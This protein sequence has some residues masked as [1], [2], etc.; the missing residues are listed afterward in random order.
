MGREQQQQVKESNREAE[1]ERKKLM[2]PSSGTCEEEEEEG[3][4]TEGELE[5]ECSGAEAGKQLI[6]KYSKTAVQSSGAVIC[7]MHSSSSP[8]KA[9]HRTHGYSPKDN[10]RKEL[11]DPCV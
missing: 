1:Q 10:R 3:E 2:G 6:Y 5:E 7:T 11:R 4:E 8:L 9:P